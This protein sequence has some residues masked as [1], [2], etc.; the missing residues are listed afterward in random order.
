ML[1]KTLENDVKF[2]RGMDRSEKGLDP[3]NA[4]QKIKSKTQTITIN[5][6][7]FPIIKESEEHY[8]IEDQEG[9]F[10][11]ISKILLDNPK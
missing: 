7:E 2:L 5:G 3:N 9:N 11:T 10:Q 6:I 1:K 4:Y 8:V